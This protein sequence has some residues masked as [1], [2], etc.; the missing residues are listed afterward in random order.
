MYL[1]TFILLKQYRGAPA[2]NGT[3]SFQKHLHRGL[4]DY[5]SSCKSVTSSRQ[6]QQPP[7]FWYNS[8]QIADKQPLCLASFM[9]NLQIQKDHRKNKTEICLPQPGLN[10]STEFVF[11]R[12]STFHCQSWIYTLTFSDDAHYSTGNI[13]G[14]AIHS[15]IFHSLPTEVSTSD[16]SQIHYQ[17][18]FEDSYR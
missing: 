16:S 12:V 1:I 7:P 3:T 9:L 10:Y 13:L 6:K 4:F 18:I 17:C 14:K 15:I 2:L 8:W 5:T 11:C